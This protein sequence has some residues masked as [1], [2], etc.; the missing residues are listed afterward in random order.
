LKVKVLR[1]LLVI[2]LA[3]SAA[4]AS[5]Y[6]WPFGHR[7]SS[8]TYPG[9]VEIQE[10]R[11]GSK[12]GGRVESVPVREGDFADKDQVLVT[13]EAPELK[14]QRAQAQARFDLAVADYDK[15]RAGP[16]PE[17]IQA[18]RQAYEAEVAHHK[19]LETGPREEEKREARS[20]LQAAEA[21]FTL[22]KEEF[23]REQ[24]LIGTNSRTNY[25]TAKATRLR[26]QRQ[27][28]RAKA[29]LDMLMAG[30]RVEEL[31]QS[32]AEVRRLKANYDLLLAGTRKEDIAMAAA[33]MEDARA[34]LQEFDAMLA[35]TIVRAPSRVFLEV[36]SVRKGDLVPPNQPI[37]RALLAQDLWVRLY[38]PETELWRIQKG[39]KVRVTLDG[40]SEVFDGS[41]MQ[42]SSI[43][44]FTP[45]NVQSA[46]ERRHQ[47]FGIKIQVPDPRGVFK[48]GMAANVI[49]TDP[50]PAGSTPSGGRGSQ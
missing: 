44:E 21:D 20:L 32:Q 24:R 37:L 27:Y 1:L 16:R 23:E 22:A 34:K 10:V 8:R 38:V 26:T 33:K 30:T 45:R 6:F 28:E 18:A 29:H 17:E 3:A 42:I 5:Y 40:S 50:A 7:E 47:V 2:L 25:D 39:E 46:D 12:I 15:A 4:G 48:A 49:F 9:I 41:V 35:E 13:F 11:L 19:M 36:V 31:E 14:T 43:S